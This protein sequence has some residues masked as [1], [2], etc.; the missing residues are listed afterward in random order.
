MGAI[1]CCPDVSQVRCVWKTNVWIV[2]LCMRG[3]NC[4]LFTVFFDF[5]VAKSFHVAFSI[6]VRHPQ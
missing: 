5:F 2:R 6:F 1:F 3:E 4:L